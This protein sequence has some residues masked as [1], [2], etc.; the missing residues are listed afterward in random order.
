M[1]AGRVPM[2]VT[3]RTQDTQRGSV[4]WLISASTW[5]RGRRVWPRA[6]R[7]WKVGEWVKITRRVAPSAPAV[8]PG[9][10]AVKQDKQLILL[11]SRG[12]P[13]AQ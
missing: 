7:A 2:R 8:G 12:A 4:I 1:A 9:L 11:E 3:C 10:P 6:W 13:P 5:T